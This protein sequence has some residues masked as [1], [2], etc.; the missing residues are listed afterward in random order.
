[1][2]LAE[3]L[4][5][6]GRFVGH[7]FGPAEW[8]NYAT[9]KEPLAHLQPRLAGGVGGECMP[10]P[11]N[12]DLALFE[13]FYVA[14]DRRNDSLAANLLVKAKETDAKIMMLVAGGFHPQRSPAD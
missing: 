14:A 7:E 5:L 1:M 12:E 3:D 9:R 4:R 6:A 2:D 13:R 11:S 10:G 8:S